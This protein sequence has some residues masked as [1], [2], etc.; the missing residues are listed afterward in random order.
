MLYIS[1]PN[2]TLR[3]ICKKEGFEGS[4]E[5]YLKQFAALNPELAKK[6]SKEQKLPACT[7]LQLVAMPGLDS[8]YSTE[9]AK[10]ISGYSLQERQVLREMQ[11][12]NHDIPTNVAAMD[13]MGEFQTFLA[14]TKK[15]LGAPVFP[16]PIYEFNRSLTNKS[17]I[18]FSGEAVKHAAHLK[19]TSTAFVDKNN[20]FALM[21]KRDELNHKWLQLKQQ[22]GSAAV[23]ARNGLE[24]Q[25][26]ELTAQIKKLLPKHV[27]ASATKYVL[28]YKPTDAA[29]L[30]SNSSSQKLARK[31]EAKIKATHLDR[32]TKTGL[33]KQ[34]SMIKGF[35]LF[36]EGVKKAATYTN[37]A[38][39][40]YAIGETYSEGGNVARTAFRE[41][42]SI[43]AGALLSTAVAGGLAG[44]GGIAI[45]SLA[46]D[47]ALGAT[48][49]VCYPVIGWVVLAVAGAALAGY[50]SYQTKDLSERVWDSVDTPYVREKIYQFGRW[51]Y[52][53]FKY[54]GEH[55]MNND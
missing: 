6:L 5:D 36:G 13:V 4:F 14:N 28:G 7:P 32:L 26:K 25:T 46:G 34:R 21:K 38:L 24:R 23:S 19:E 10:I 43:Y 33:A 30:R 18:K 35:K 48:I 52:E 40:A 27:N 55:I 20:L 50:V 12:N 44:L 3:E 31:G 37:Y 42:T 11:E 54:L 45:G 47:M 53:D 51:I 29:K 49:L 41:G 39:A 15:K 2:D 8:V 1:G 16:T 22:K 17:L 9:V